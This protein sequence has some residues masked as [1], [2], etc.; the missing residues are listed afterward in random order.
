MK[1]GT[2]VGARRWKKGH[3]HGE[4]GKE[5]DLSGDMDGPSRIQTGRGKRSGKCAV[6]VFSKKKC[7]PRSANSG[8]KATEDG[9]SNSCR[10][11]I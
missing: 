3:D 1:K 2:C 9:T 4:V 5:N 7:T 6:V 11:I 8:K 10:E